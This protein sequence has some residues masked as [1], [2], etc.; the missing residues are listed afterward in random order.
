M[1]EEAR[2]TAN[3]GADKEAVFHA[4]AQTCEAEKGVSYKIVTEDGLPAESYAAIEHEL[5]NAVDKACGKGRSEAPADA[6]DDDRQHCQVKRA[7]L[8][9]LPDGD[10]AQH[11][12]SGDE[13]R[14]FADGAERKV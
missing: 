6:E 5:D 12:C 2:S 9:H 1:G 7:A 10:K 4:L 8:R 14:A 11:R 3:D 13:D